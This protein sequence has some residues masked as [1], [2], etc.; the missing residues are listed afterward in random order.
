MTAVAARLVDGF[1][2]LDPLEQRLVWNQIAQAV[3]PS[4]YGELTDEELTAIADGTF[5]LL[6]KEEADAARPGR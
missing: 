4:D 2:R 3:A 1:K 5:V 6:D